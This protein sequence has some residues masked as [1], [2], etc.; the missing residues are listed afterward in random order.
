MRTGHKVA[1]AVPISVPLVLLAWL[2]AVLM[3][4]V[5][6]FG[7]CYEVVLLFRLITRN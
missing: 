1:A 6:V 3:T 4:N 2:I 5:I 7:L